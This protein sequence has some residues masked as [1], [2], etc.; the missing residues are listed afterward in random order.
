MSE[1]CPS[2]LQEQHIKDIDTLY[3]MAMPTWVRG[4]LLTAIGTLFAIYAVSWAYASV[5][6]ATKDEV[7]DIRAEI[8]QDIRDIKDML[9]QMKGAK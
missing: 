5:T 6:Y 7:K 9:G 2:R 4:M 1:D 8:R 3:R